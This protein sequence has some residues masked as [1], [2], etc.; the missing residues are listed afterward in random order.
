MTGKDS[1]IV[2]I[3]NME[4]SLYA[5]SSQTVKPGKA[6][7]IIIAYARFAHDFPA[8]S[9]SP[10]Y[11]FKAAELARAIHK[12]KEAILY[13]DKIYKN[14]PDNKKAPT[15]LFLIAFTYE[16][17]LKD[18]ANA[19]IYYREFIEKYPDNQLADD[20]QY[21]LKYLEKSPEELIKMFEDNEDD[22]AEKTG[23]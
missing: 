9:L 5:D 12:G 17:T 14:Y 2:S 8:D 7:E 21:S 4:K 10:E 13:Y 18:T 22:I 23:K 15:A 3:Q 6:M 19:R 20:A 16:N 1:A 11:C